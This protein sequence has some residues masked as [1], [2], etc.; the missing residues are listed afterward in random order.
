MQMFNVP[1]GGK[2]VTEQGF[3]DYTAEFLLTRGPFAILGCESLLLD[4]TAM[5]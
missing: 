4:L 2:S 5:S 3:T 1:N